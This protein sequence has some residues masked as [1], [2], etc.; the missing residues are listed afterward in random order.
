MALAITVI[1]LTK[2]LKGDVIE[3]LTQ[4]FW[5]IQ[6][7]VVPAVIGITAIMGDRSP[8]VR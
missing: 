8:G 6:L 4:L 1:H 3:G 7:T 2:S 5:I